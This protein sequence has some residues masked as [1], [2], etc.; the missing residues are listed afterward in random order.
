VPRSASILPDTNVV[1]RYLL[2]DVPDQYGRAEKVFEDVRTGK[3][4]A[5]IL[6]S[7]LVDCVLLAKARHGAGRLLSFDK[8]L[9]KL[10]QIS[11]DAAR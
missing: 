3:A 2:Q 6:E 11:P 5:V 1:L 7:V 4:K 8:D 10:S 9:N